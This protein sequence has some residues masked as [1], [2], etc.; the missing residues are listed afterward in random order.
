M[1][2]IFPAPV[3]MELIL[4][5]LRDE[6]VHSDL[7]MEAEGTLVPESDEAPHPATNQDTE[8]LDHGEIPG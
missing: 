4:S 7:F 3:M 6:Q 5:V 1:A 2:Y 8:Q